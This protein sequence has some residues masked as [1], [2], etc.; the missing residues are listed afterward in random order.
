MSK[1]RVALSYPP[2]GSASAHLLHPDDEAGGTDHAS[3]TEA[4]GEARAMMIA[5]IYV[6]GSLDELTVNQ[7]D[8]VAALLIEDRD[9]ADRDQD[10]DLYCKCVDALDDVLDQRIKAQA[11][12]RPS[13]LPTP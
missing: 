10:V 1:T 12:P 11:N 3:G 13:P 9:A 5:D 8:H 6:K 2:P 4:E 7:L